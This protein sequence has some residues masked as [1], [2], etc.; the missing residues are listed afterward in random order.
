ML[1]DLEHPIID[2]RT[3]IEPKMGFKELQVVMYLFCTPLLHPR[4]DGNRGKGF[5]TRKIIRS[6][7]VK[8]ACIFRVKALGH[9]LAGRVSLSIVHHEI[10]DC[11]FKE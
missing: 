2:G 4:A 7:T 5:Y 6:F 8:V 9:D 11:F 3:L 1:V 10:Y